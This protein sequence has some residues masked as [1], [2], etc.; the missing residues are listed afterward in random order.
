MQEHTNDMGES[1]NP[2]LMYYL[3]CLPRFIKMS[4]PK[5]TLRFIFSKNFFSEGN[6][7]GIKSCLTFTILHG[8][9][10]SRC[11]NLFF[12]SNS[13]HIHFKGLG[14][15]I[16][17]PNLKHISINRDW[18]SNQFSNLKSLVSSCSPLEL[19]FS[20]WDSVNTENVTLLRRNSLSWISATALVV[21]IISKLSNENYSNMWNFQN[22]E[23]S[24]SF[25]FLFQIFKYLIVFQH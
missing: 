24:F 20:L 21:T 13:L 2:I 4:S 19:Q 9:A 1:I 5:I 3:I 12:F 8:S 7:I 10:C 18:S 15:L 25:V 6:F 11:R 16:L 23:F 14:V 17:R 22:H